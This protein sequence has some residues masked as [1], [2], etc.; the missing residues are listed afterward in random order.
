[1]SETNG[2]KIDAAVRFAAEQRTSLDAKLQ[3]IFMRNYGITKENEKEKSE[4]DPGY[5][6]WGMYAVDVSMR[7]ARAF[8]SIKNNTGAYETMC[9]FTY[10]LATNEFWQKNANVIMPLIHMAL[11][12]HRD[13]VFLLAERARR[14]EYSSYDALISASRAAP[15]EIFPVIAY[16]VGGPALMA[17]ASLAL[18]TELAPFF[19]G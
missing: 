8:L 15:L 18:K 12:T 16:L 19:L 13:G 3:E 4:Q 6:A 11:N 14:N 1:M 2:D 5:M 10:Q 9:D 7:I 17:N